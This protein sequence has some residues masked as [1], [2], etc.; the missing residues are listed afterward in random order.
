M[1]QKEWI[2]IFLERRSLRIPN[3]RPLYAYKSRNTEYPIFY[4]SRNPHV[5]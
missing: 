5:R 2:P 1:N 4:N 3:G